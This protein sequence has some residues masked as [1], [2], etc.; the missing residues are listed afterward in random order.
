MADA[1]KAGRIGSLQGSLAKAME[2]A[3]R[4]EWQRV[5]GEELPDAGEE[6][7]RILFVGI[8]RGLLDFLHRHRE[9]LITDRVDGD[10]LHRHHAEFDW[11]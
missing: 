6:D 3:M 11:I 9:D 8:A 7:R 4:E 2:D 1:L 10:D 5:K